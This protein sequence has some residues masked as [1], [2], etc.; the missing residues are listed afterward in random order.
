MSVIIRVFWWKA[1]VK[2]FQPVGG[3]GLLHPSGLAGLVGLELS[4]AMES[5]P[6]GSLL[7]NSMQNIMVP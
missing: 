3:A 6:D 1:E 2:T 5:C 7:A 4:V